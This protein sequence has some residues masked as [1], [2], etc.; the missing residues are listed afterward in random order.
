MQPKDHHPEARGIFF[1]QVQQL[2]LA[3][4]GITMP[5]AAILGQLLLQFKRQP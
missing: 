4:E 5:P 1:T 3:Q 2:L